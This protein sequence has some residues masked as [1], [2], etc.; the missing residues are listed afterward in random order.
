VQR[1]QTSLGYLHDSGRASAPSEVNMHK[2]SQ[3][4]AVVQLLASGAYIEQV[5][6]APL[7][8]HLYHVRDSAPFAGGLAQQLLKSRAIK[9]SCRA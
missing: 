9:Q 4:N 3:F 8:C 7:S 6:E 2:N 5:S 1:P